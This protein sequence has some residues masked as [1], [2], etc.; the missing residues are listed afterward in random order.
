[1]IE[2]EFLDL[3]LSICKLPSQIEPPSWTKDSRFLCVCRTPDEL[4]IVCET[5]LVPQGTSIELENRWAAFRVAGILDFSL[6]GILSS[7]V[8]PLA[9]ADISVFAVSTFDTDYVLVRSDDRSRAKAVLETSF[10]VSDRK[11]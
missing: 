11:S 4:S 9:K 5:A 2:L 3:E 6:T 1:M 8:D 10:T 7:I